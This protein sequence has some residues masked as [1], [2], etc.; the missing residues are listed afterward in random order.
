MAG[1]RLLPCLTPLPSV[2]CFDRRTPMNLGHWAYPIN[3]LRNAEV[4]VGVLH[5]AD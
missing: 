3:Q 4:V 5:G 1:D 2:N